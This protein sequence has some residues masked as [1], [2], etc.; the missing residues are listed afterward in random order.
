MKPGDLVTMPG[1]KDPGA[2]LGVGIVLEDPHSVHTKGT[3]KR[4]KI[5]WLDHE[6]V[7]SEP[8]DWLEVINDNGDDK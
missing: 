3:R 5:L 4:V 7:C 2:G 1:S 6:E 8:V